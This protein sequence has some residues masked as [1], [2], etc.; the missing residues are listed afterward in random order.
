M[1][2]QH[3]LFQAIKKRL[4]REK[5]S[6]RAAT[7]RTNPPRDAQGV[8][9]GHVPSIERAAVV[10]NVLGIFFRI[11][12]TEN[13]TCASP[14]DPELIG[15]LTERIVRTHEECGAEITPRRAVELAA[16]VYNRIVGETKDKDDRFVRVGEY[17]VELRQTLSSGKL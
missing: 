16:V 17:I 2:T 8:L 13:G 4:A 14:I 15:L 1:K 6:A 9:E 3:K 11:S 10:A 7:L 5:T 12:A